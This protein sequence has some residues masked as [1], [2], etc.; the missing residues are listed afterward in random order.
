MK[1]VTSVLLLVVAALYIQA[2]TNEA[3]LAEMGGEDE[4]PGRRGG[5]IL[6][7]GSFVLSTQA[8][9]AGNDEEELGEE[10]ESGRRGGTTTSIPEGGF[11]VN[12]GYDGPAN[13]AG[14]EETLFKASKSTDKKSGLDHTNWDDRWRTG[15]CWHRRDFG[16]ES[17]GIT[18]QHRCRLVVQQKQ[19]TRTEGYDG[20]NQRQ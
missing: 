11:K 7:S 1:I 10:D 8:N 18:V 3:D 2:V 13:R 9:R 16:S 14:Y 5:A 17:E 4:S 12:N 6:T 19:Q 15:R 20:Q